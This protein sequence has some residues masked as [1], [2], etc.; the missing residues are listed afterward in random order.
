MRKSAARSSSSSTMLRP[1]SQPFSPIATKSPPSSTESIDGFSGFFEGVRRLEKRSVCME[2]SPKAHVRSL[3]PRHPD[4]MTT[5]LITASGTPFPSAVAAP[6]R[7]IAC[8]R[9]ERRTSPPLRAVLLRRV[10]DV[11]A[12]TRRRTAI[13]E[14]AAAEGPAPWRAAPRR[15]RNDGDPRR[16]L[17]AFPS[18]NGEAFPCLRLTAPK[19]R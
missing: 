5:S 18:R 12:F 11:C 10:R 3:L 2:R 9:L 19:I 4:V 17:I 6:Q 8:R 1:S 13:D 14:P 15:R 7:R 16:P